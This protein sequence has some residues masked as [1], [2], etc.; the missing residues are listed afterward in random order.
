LTRR[1]WRLNRV[2]TLVIGLMAVSGG[3]AQAAT[4]DGASRVPNS[5]SRH[6]VLRLSEENSVQCFQT[7]SAAISNATGGRVTSAPNDPQ[8]ALSSKSLTN[9]INAAPTL[10]TL[11]SGYVI[12][13]LYEHIN[14]GGATFTVTA[15]QPCT[16]PLEDEY[17]IP[18][19]VPYG[20]N[21]VVSS[22]R[23]Y[24]NCWTKLFEHEWLGG[25]AYGYTPY[26]SWVGSYFNDL[27]TS[28]RWS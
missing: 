22:F 5:A 21:D 12:G 23:S 15:G 9:K 20:W 7:F 13:V 18:S 2:I 16:G 26:S 11:A 4:T 6:C 28:V 24:N 25:A 3:A 17:Y 19:L 27:T 1:S 8:A 10:Q 14:Y